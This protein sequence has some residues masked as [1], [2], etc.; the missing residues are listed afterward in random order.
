MTT[1]AIDLFSGA[2]GLAEGLESTGIHV[3]VAVELHP[4][5]ALTYAFNHPDTTVLVGDIHH[6]DMNFL[7][8]C[9][10]RRIGSDKVDIVVGGPPCQGFSTAGKKLFDDPRNDLFNQFVRVIEYFR[11]RM[12]LLENVPGFKK[13]YGGQAFNK[14]L[15]MFTELEYQC[16]D[17]I[18]EASYYGVPQRRTRFVMV[19]WLQD[20]AKPFKF[21]AYTHEDYKK[22]EQLTIFN[23][24]TTES[25][26]FVTVYEA[27]SDLEFLNPGWE[28]HQYQEALQSD[29][30]SAR[31][32]ECN[33]L[34]NHLATR[35]RP[36]GI[37][38]F[39]YIPEGG[40]ISSVPSHLKIA[41]KTMARLDRNKISNAVL[42]LPDDLL[43]YHHHRIL[44]VR[45]MARLQTFDDNYVF[46]GKRTSGFV[47][48]RVDAPQYTQVGNAVPPLLGRVLGASLQTALCK[49]IQDI[50]SLKE[51]RKRHQWVCG[52][53]GFAGYM[54]DPKAQGQIDLFNIFGEPLIL[55][56]TTEDIP[57]YLANSSYDWTKKKNLKRGQ[58]APGIEPRSVP[59]Y[60]Q[61]SQ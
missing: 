27:L 23:E 51:R 55:P 59:V 6:L 28:S 61:Q 14:A 2:G 30:Q 54:L 49:T 56:V 58:W 17:S 12:F 21:P 3:A 22:V 16:I 43:H 31:R 47:E 7:A 48:R 1:I 42:S 36:K 8:Q 60:M 29:F 20:K 32:N 15:Q 50:R 9:I 39:S 26:S 52:S 35:H 11:P 57:V 5:P 10:R 38:M 44:S 13:M 34:F 24:L 53:S 45:E 25:K 37:E 19:G 4:Q 33:L 41:K 18:I 40:T 46:F